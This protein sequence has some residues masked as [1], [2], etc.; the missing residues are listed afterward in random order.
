MPARGKFLITLAVLLAIFLFSPKN[1]FGQNLLKNSDFEEG[2]DPWEI[3][4]GGATASIIS[5]PI[6][7]GISAVEVKN[8]STFSYGIQQIVDKISEGKTYRLLGYVK[9][10]DANVEKAFLRIG[11]YD[12]SGE[13]KSV[14]DSN[15][16][17]GLSDWSELVVEK[18]V[19]PGI[20]SAKVRAILSSKTKGVLA[21]AYFDDLS[22]GEV[23]LSTSAT[24]TFA[25][26]PTPTKMLTPTPTNTPTPKDYS[27]IFISEFMV[28]PESGNEW[29]ELF[30]NNDFEVD[31]YSWY[32]DDVADGGSLPRQIF[33]AIPAKSYKQFSLNSTAYFN[34]GG[35]DVRLLNASQAEKDKVSFETSIKGKSWSKDKN[36]KWCQLDPTPNAPN[37]DCPSEE[38]NLTSAPTPTPTQM[39]TPTLTP[40]SKLTPTLKITPTEATKSGEVLGEEEE[41]AGG[42]YPLEATEEAEKIEETTPSG[43]RNSKNK[44]L[45]GIFIGVGLMSIFGVAFSLWYT[46]LK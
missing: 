13:Q 18:V 39:P 3:S 28:Y 1:V 26:T 37:P 31:L 17:T 7:T 30:N 45:G 21:F 43:K 38:Q 36:G 24:P 8:S 11:W 14:S 46:K 12:E 16:V 34:N 25:P 19:P 4:G 27:N 15:Q 5:N 42:F 40:T 35:D 2:I 23:T 22:F 32:L 29:V 33:G 44:I 41:A 10:T 20:V 9:I 6:R